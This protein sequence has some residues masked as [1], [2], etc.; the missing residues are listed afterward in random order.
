M[1]DVWR[2]IRCAGSLWRAAFWAV[3]AIAVLLVLA[4]GAVDAPFLYRIGENG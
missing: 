2:L 1:L 4:N 3:F